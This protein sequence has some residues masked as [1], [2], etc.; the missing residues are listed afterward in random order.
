MQREAAQGALISAR[1]RSRREQQQ[2]DEGIRVA[3]KLAGRQL[4][5]NQFFGIFTNHCG[6]VGDQPRGGRQAISLC[7]HNLRARDPVYATPGLD[8]VK[9]F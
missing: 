4:V 3:L 8:D 7:L 1:F 9:K 2:S 5:F 6:V